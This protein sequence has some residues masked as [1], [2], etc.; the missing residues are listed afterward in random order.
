MVVEMVAEMDTQKAY[1]VVVRMVKMMEDELVESKA[2]ERAVVMA[3]PKD[4]NMVEQM[5]EK[6]VD[7]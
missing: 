4:L 6:Q 3:V 7:E 1:L 5:G 2:V